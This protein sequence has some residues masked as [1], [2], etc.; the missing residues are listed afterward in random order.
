MKQLTMSFQM[1]TDMLKEFAKEEAEERNEDAEAETW[2]SV[3]R[4]LGIPL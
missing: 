2:K 4:A 3:F 1:E